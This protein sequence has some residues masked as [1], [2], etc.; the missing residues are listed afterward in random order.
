MKSAKGY[1]PIYLPVG[2]HPEL[3]THGQGWQGETVSENIELCKYQTIEPVFRKYLPKQGRILE[4][5]CGLGRWVFYLRRL[6]YDVT[7][8][9]LSDTAVRLAKEYEP[10]I[11]IQA[12]DVLHT[13][14]PDRSFDAVISLGVVEHFEDGPELAFREARRILKD[15]GLF[16]V[17]V[18]LQNYFRKLFIYQLRRIRRTQW[19]LNHT[20]ISFEEYHYSRE[21]ITSLLRE[22]QFDVI[23]TTYDDF[24][25][26][27]N[28]A[29][30]ADSRFFRSDRKWEL[31]ALGR[32]I[33]RALRPI[34][35]WFNA[36]GILC[37][38]RK[39]TSAPDPTR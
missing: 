27:K 21:R 4:A 1:F 10:G 23:E 29:L 18:P 7:G 35:P 5:G 3:E 30:Y 32:A 26:P 34:S 8:I 11:P 20:P 36:A 33:D 25:Y 22:S 24:Q 28:M 17:T 12:D 14:Y 38:C 19:M 15:D 2:H 37:V 39:R 9:D 31:N 6:G 16:F 13:G